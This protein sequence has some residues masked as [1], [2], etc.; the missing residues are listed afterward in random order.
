MK[1]VFNNGT[2][3]EFAN[4]DLSIY[5][6]EMRLDVSQVTVVDKK[7]PSMEHTSVEIKVHCG[8]ARVIDGNR[9][10]ITEEK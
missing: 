1:L 8:K 3:V 5:Y 7:D 10:R 6:G 2:Q 4:D 9:V